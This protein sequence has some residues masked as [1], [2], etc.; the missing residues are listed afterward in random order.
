MILVS[1]TTCTSENSIWI[2]KLA[3]VDL[4]SFPDRPEFVGQQVSFFK[5]N[6]QSMVKSTGRGG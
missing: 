4:G 2:L 1:C 5:R 3:I 6:G